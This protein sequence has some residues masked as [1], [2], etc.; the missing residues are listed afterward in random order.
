[1]ILR[2]YRIIRIMNRSL[3][4]I[5]IYW[6][7]SEAVNLFKKERKRITQQ[8]RGI[9]QCKNGDGYYNRKMQQKDFREQSFLFH[10]AGADDFW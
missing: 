7:K 5:N 6:K 9:T 8:R 2:V 10:G 3:N 4:C 1:M